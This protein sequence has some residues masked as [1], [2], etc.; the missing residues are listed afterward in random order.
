MKIAKIKSSSIDE[1]FNE[2]EQN[3]RGSLKQISNAYE[4]TLNG[5]FGLGSIKGM[6]LKNGIS[7]LNFKLK[8]ND[9]FILKINS[10]NKLPIYFAYCTEGSLQHSF[11]EDSKK[12]VLQK[13]QTGILTCQKP[14]ENYLI[15]KKDEATQISL[16]VVNT[17]ISESL[18]GLCLNKKLKNTFFEN[19]TESAV[20]ISAYN[21]E[22]SEK[23]KE[24]NNIKHT[25]IVK[26]LM[27]AGII[28]MILALE[29][30]QHKQ[31][32]INLL[33]P[34][35]S[36]TTKE[37][38]VIKELS[39]FICS[40]PEK[41]YSIKALSEKAGLSKRKLQEG[42]RLLHNRTVRDF[43]INERMKKSK[44]LIR[45]TDLNIS[46]VV[47]SIGFSSRSYFSKIFKEKYNCSPKF[48]KENQNLMAVTA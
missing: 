9:D 23:I 42:F 32:L 26:R 10:S 39:A 15:F 34:T 40:T 17:T 11:G 3:F 37:L 45:T 16:I 4:L 7:Y 18:E 28:H 8:L 13:Y 25:G 44:I 29:I 2:L 22:I 48:Y 24:V 43:I 46:E 33:N 21:M 1:I 14:E 35:S 41:N 47:Y 6:S 36:L 31:N 30:Q 19:N 5:Q 38:D 12:S 20:Y 27:T